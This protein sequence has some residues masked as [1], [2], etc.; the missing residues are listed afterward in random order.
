MSA[1]PLPGILGTVAPV[2]DNYGYLAGDHIGTIYATA[3]RYSL[4]LLIALLL[5]LAAWLVRAVWRRKRS[6]VPPGSR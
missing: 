4:Y 1:A 3:V 5:L 2:L 6:P